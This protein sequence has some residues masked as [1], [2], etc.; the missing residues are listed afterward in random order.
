STGRLYLRTNHTGGYYDVSGATALPANTYTHVTA[1]FDAST[2][3]GRLYV[4]GVQDG[5]ATMFRAEAPI[6]ASTISGGSQSFVGR[7]DEVAIYRYPLNAGQVLSH[8]ALRPTPAT[9][10]GSGVVTYLVA[11]NPDGTVRTTTMTVADQI[12]TL[13]QLPLCGY[14]ITSPPSIPA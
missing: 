4:N 7:L 12:V 13:R 9:T 2:N 14:L 10:T 11:P 5:S 3:V 8:V 1:T 6:I